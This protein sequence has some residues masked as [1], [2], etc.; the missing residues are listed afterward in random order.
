[1][2]SLLNMDIKLVPNN[3]ECEAVAQFDFYNE[4][5]A[6]KQLQLVYFPFGFMPLPKG[7]FIASVKSACFP[8][9]MHSVIARE[10]PVSGA[11]EVIWN[12]NP[13]DQRGTSIPNDDVK[14]I[15][16]LAAIIT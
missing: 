2:A 13:K 16:V 11:L 9:C 8:N 14:I 4:W 3:Y 12:P 10:N 7:Y 6:S 15:E 5:L 1:M